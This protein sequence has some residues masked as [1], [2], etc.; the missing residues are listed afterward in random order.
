MTINIMKNLRYFQALS[1]FL[2]AS[3]LITCKKD[4]APTTEHEG[5]V[6]WNYENPNWGA[7]GFGDCLGKVQS[8]VNIDTSKT[9][10]AKLNDIVFSY[11]PFNYKIV[12]NGHTLQINNNGNNSIFIDGMSYKFKQLHFHYKSEHEINNTQYPMEIHFVHLNDSTGNIAV[13]G[14]MVEEGSANAVI[15]KFW[16]NFPL[17]KEVEVTS[18]DLISL[19]DLMPLDQKYYTYVGSL[20]TPPCSQGLKWLVM[21]NKIQASSAQ[22]DA[23][24][25]IYKNNARPLQPLNSRLVLEK[26]N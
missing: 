23:F 8:P 25:A 16:S 6:H 18:Q 10:K 24:K 26:T 15:A 12:D 11:N 17:V 14:V 1:L 21:K 2:I 19:S 22:I 7:I 20:T 9:V 3:L 5:D 13:I 4:K